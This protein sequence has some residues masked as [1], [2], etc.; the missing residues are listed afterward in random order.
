MFAI[1]ESSIRHLKIIRKTHLSRN[2]LD[3]AMKETHRDQF[4]VPGYVDRLNLD[5][6]RIEQ[7]VLRSRKPLSFAVQGLDGVL[8]TKF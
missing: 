1:S 3:E 6:D 4:S 7:P 8:L 5:T 2:G